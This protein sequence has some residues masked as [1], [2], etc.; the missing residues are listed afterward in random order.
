MVI[1]LGLTPNLAANSALL[2][3]RAKSDSLKAASRTLTSS[4][5]NSVRFFFILPVVS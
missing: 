5:E 3:P 2:C 1:D 4:V